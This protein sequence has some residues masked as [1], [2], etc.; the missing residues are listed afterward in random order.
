VLLEAVEV[1]VDEV[2]LDPLLGLLA[3]EYTQGV[4]PVPT[5]HPFLDAAALAALA[6]E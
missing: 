4:P 6:E 3:E 1:L 5:V 2:V